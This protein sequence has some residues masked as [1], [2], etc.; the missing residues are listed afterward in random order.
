MKFIAI[1]FLL[2]SLLFLKNE[3]TA[4]VKK[5]ELFKNVI[6]KGIEKKEYK[7]A[8]NN[9]N[10]IE[11]VFSSLFLMYKTLISSQDQAVCTFTPSCSEYGIMAVKHFGL[12]KGGLMTTDRLTRCNG[13]SPTNYEI[14][15]KTGLL[16]DNPV[17][18]SK[19]PT[20]IIE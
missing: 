18:L 5:T 15:K 12:I 16:K 4:Q 1:V 19:N 9:K 13:L 2:G 10:E 7:E 11:F 8:Q 14:D 3:A 6:E 17:I 20:I